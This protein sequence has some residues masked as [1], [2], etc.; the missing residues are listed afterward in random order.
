MTCPI[1]HD[2]HIHKQNIAHLFGLSVRNASVCVCV[3]VCV[4]NFSKWDGSY[5]WLLVA[6]PKR[7][8]FS[9]RS[10]RRGNSLGRLCP[11]CSNNSSRATFRK[12][13]P[14]RQL[15]VFEPSSNTASS[16]R[17]NLRHDQ[18]TFWKL[19]SLKEL[20]TQHNENKES[21]DQLK[22]SHEAT[23]TTIYCVSEKDNCCS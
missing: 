15:D 20:T 3:C 7:I 21:N 16:V 19:F 2:N 23:A 5:T 10:T 13:K 11:S 14:W 18:V 1:T 6:R 4:W 17:T 12:P 9:A 22:P 8:S